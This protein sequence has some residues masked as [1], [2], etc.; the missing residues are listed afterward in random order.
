M[1]FRH[2]TPERLGNHFP[3]I[4]E[5]QGVHSSPAEGPKLS[6]RGVL[7]TCKDAAM[8]LYVRQLC[9]RGGFTSE[10]FD[11]THTFIYTKTPDQSAQVIAYLSQNIDEMRADNS[12]S[13]GGQLEGE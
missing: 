4:P 9:D 12:G 10:P 3:L 7:V 8:K 11:D 13:S 2:Q 5:S 1:L 6:L